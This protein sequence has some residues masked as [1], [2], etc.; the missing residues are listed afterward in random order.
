MALTGGFNSSVNSFV[1][2]TGGG[3]GAYISNTAGQNGGNG[4]WPGGGG[5]G[6]AASDNGF[7]SG[8]GGNGAN[9]IVVV[10]TYLSEPWPTDQHGKNWTPNAERTLYTC[11]DGVQMVVNPEWSRGGNHRPYQPRLRRT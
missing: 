5:G 10:I 2:G 8:A 6:G 9:G 4:G 7:T 1:A 11:D 3:G